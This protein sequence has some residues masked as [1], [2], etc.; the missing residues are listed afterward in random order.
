[1]VPSPLALAQASANRFQSREVA[2]SDSGMQVGS[3]TP[4]DDSRKTTH[5]NPGNKSALESGA[6]PKGSPLCFQPGIGWQQ[7][8]Q[9][10][11]PSVE[12]VTA[13]SATK[14]AVG[15]KSDGTG[16]A[17]AKRSAKGET[18]LNE[19]PSSA[20]SV[21]AAEAALGAGRTS[22]TSNSAGRSKNP[23]LGADSALNPAGG[24]ASSQ[25][26]GAG[27]GVAMLFSHPSGT[28]HSSDSVEELERR[29]YISPAKLRRM[30]R[31]APDLETRI[32]LRKLSEKQAS[33]QAKPLEGSQEKTAGEKLGQKL[34]RISSS[35][36]RSASGSKMPRTGDRHGANGSKRTHSHT[37]S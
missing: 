14:G 27:T 9:A 8:P 31:D 23:S 22:E 35:S 5:S 33:K 10:V 13:S 29:S 4:Q 15:V 2:P 3:S 6:T 28:R 34:E 32:K 12:R 26:T 37:S 16:V 17:L 25:K 30:I 7:V 18:M 21:A 11:S 19:C 20:A 36:S 1:M 24:L